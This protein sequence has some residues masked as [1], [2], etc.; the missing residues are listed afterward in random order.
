MDKWMKKIIWTGIGFFLVAMNVSAF[1]N[2]TA[3]ELALNARSE[4]NSDGAGF[5]PPFSGTDSYYSKMA[6]TAGG[7]DIGFEGFDDAA[8]DGT[9]GPG[10][11]YDDGA[12]P[13]GWSEYRVGFRLTAGMIAS[14]PMANIRQNGV[15]TD[16]ATAKSRNNIA[17]PDLG[18]SVEDSFAS[19]SAELSVGR[20][21]GFKFALGLGTTSLESDI[22]LNAESKTGGLDGADQAELATLLNEAETET[23]IDIADFFN[24]PVLAIGVNYA[25]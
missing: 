20:V 10:F 4:I 16:A 3:F 25:F 24:R 12:P 11:D 19:S 18:S 15:G 5:V 13:V 1:E 8:T 6:A 7:L 23:K 17:Y 14:D 2:V 9:A 21:T 22:G